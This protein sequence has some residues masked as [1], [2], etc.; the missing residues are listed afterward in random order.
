MAGACLACSLEDPF[1][2]GTLWLPAVY[3]DH[4]AHCLT[5]GFESSL[6]THGASCP[7]RLS[8]AAKD[9]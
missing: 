3:T 8:V 6:G 7:R 5:Q 2:S 9:V 4:T 1:T